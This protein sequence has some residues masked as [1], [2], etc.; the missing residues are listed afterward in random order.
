MINF[1][2]QI[3]WFEINKDFT[4][5]D[6]A[7]TSLK[8]KDVLEKIEEYVDHACTNPHNSDS[9]FAYKSLKV[10][11]DTRTL[12]SEYLGCESDSII[13]TAG[14]TY[15]LNTIADAVEP[16]LNKGDQIILTNAE[17]AS[18]ILPWFRIREKKGIE[19]IFA[20]ASNF[21]QPDLKHDI[22]N[23]INSKTKLISFANGTNLFGSKLDANK[24]AK[25]IK[26]INPNILVCVD[27]TQYISHH[28]MVLKNS[29][30]DFLAASAHKMMGPT[31]IGLLYISPNLIDKLKPNILGGGMNDNIRKQYYTLSSGYHKFEA[32]TPNIMGIYGWNAALK[33]YNQIDMES[34]RKRIYELKKYMDNELSKIKG[35]TIFNKG[36]DSFITLF[37]YEGVFSQDMASYLGQNKIIVRS[38]LSCAK[39][40]DEI[41]HQEHAVRVSMHFYTTK[42][43]IDNFLI[44]MKKY[45]KGD[46][47]NDII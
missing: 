6:S 10:M 34:E 31:G 14:A 47:L 21:N 35:I 30:I 8:P 44:A 3:K 29:N 4:Y 27:A 38:G 22:F 9:N 15:S 18:N 41:I 37:S 25:K 12:L 28:K 11:Q 33:I 20:D 36:I 23:H 13:F 2:K 26:T 43:H 16:F 45:K 24:I 40:S 17:H 32:G 39:L 19:I 1:N 7:A 5:L 46:E 42:K